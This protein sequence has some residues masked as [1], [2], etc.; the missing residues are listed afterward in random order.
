MDVGMGRWSL[1]AT[2]QFLPSAH[3][4]QRI[5]AKQEKYHQG[6]LARD[7][8]E[9]T[10]ADTPGVKGVSGPGWGAFLESL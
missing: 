10:E 4:M 8:E 5:R 7:S 1:C 3:R 6:Q 2:A 9:A